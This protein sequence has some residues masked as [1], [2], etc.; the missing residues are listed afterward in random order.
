MKLILASSSQA[1]IKLLQK[2]MIPFESISPDI[3]ESPLDNESAYELTRRLAEGKALKIASV[4]NDKALI[5]GCD[6]LGELDG[7]FL[8]KPLTHDKATLMLKAQRNKKVTYTT[9]LCLLNSDSQAFSLVTET[10]QVT[11]RNFSNEEIESYLHKEKPY[12]CAGG[13]R[14]EGLGIALVQSLQGND[15]NTLIGIPLIELITLLKQQG[16]KLY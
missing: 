8:C 12:H 14:I 2:L 3:D 15:P 6:Q 10:F 16:F 4:I 5:I 7:Q 9:S 11:Y 13:L 1:R